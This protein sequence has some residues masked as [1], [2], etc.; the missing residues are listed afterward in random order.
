MPTTASLAQHRLPIILSCHCKRI[1]LSISEEPEFLTECNC[2]LCRRYGALWAYFSP[3]SVKLRCQEA[4]L[5]QYIQG[6]KTLAVNACNTCFCITHWH[7]LQEQANAK[8][9]V[10]FRLAQESLSQQYTIRH[11][12]GANTWTYLD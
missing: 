7:T 9:G 8:M 1:Q 11:L 10:N 5:R 3:S 2:S 4:Q 6:D 12:D